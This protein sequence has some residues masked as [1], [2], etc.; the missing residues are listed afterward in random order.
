[1]G[2]IGG[3]A[4]RSPEGVSGVLQPEKHCVTLTLWHI[5]VCEQLWALAGSDKILHDFIPRESL[6]AALICT[7]KS[8]Y[9]SNGRGHVG[10]GNIAQ[11]ISA[12]KYGIW[13]FCPQSMPVLVIYQ[14]GEGEGTDG[15]FLPYIQGTLQP[16]NCCSFVTADKWKLFSKYVHSTFGDGLLKVKIYFAMNK[17][18]MTTSTLTRVDAVHQEYPVPFP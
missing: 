16:L 7:G 12:P 11:L 10:K 14:A 1:M 2:A 4:C 13:Y 5:E 17:W 18:R 15:Y 6:L 8:V 3:A 9:C